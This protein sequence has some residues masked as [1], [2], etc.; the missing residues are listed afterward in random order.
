[1]ETGHCGCRNYVVYHG[2]LTSSTN[3]NTP[4]QTRKKRM[5]AEKPGINRGCGYFKGLRKVRQTQNKT[6]R[7]ARM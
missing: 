5:V 6:G 4:P 1:M 7:R 3:I 2:R